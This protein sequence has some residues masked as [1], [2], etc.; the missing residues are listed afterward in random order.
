LTTKPDGDFESLRTAFLTS[1]SLRLGI[2]KDN[3]GEFADHLFEALLKGCERALAIA[4]DNGILSAHEAKSAARHRL[5]LDEL[6]TIQKNLALLTTPDELYIQA[7]LEFEERYRQQVGN[8]HA[9]ITPPH[10]DVARKLPIDRI[11][12]PLNVV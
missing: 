6:A 3:L 1:L 2:P 8:R 7:I 4:I 10:F 12:V 9:H 11:Y 5:I